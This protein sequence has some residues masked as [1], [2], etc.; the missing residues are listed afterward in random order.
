MRLILHVG[1][2]KTATSA[3]QVFARDN[4][5]FLETQGLF[6]PLDPAGR[7]PNHN[8]LAR[9]VRHAFPRRHR[10]VR[11]LLDT[12]SS[13]PEDSTVLISGE[14]FSAS[15]DRLRLWHGLDR[16]DFRQLQS[17][18]LK[19]LAR[20][21]H[22]HD[23]EI[24]LVFRRADEY[25]QSLYQTLIAEDRYRG[26]FDSFLQF[27]APLFDYAAQ[28]QAFEAAFAT[29]TTLSFHLPRTGMVENMFEK[30]GF[31]SHLLSAQRRNVSIDA[32]LTYW[33]AA[34]NLAGKTPPAVV[35]QQRNFC[36]SDAAR[37]LFPHFGLATFWRSAD[38]RKRFH[39]SAAKDISP[40]LFPE[41]QATARHHAALSD[42]ERDRV[43]K[44]FRRWQLSAPDEQE[45][46]V[47]AS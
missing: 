32:R 10:R 3:M 35:S 41:C 29:V 40:K 28:R 5:E 4:R 7:W 2:H 44:A 1:T 13:Y 12:I 15:C 37:T 19:R 8:W 22:D 17:R 47:R 6:Y 21:L 36:K 26:S 45:Q 27:S 39:N 25:A 11:N 18:Y 43:A 34:S 24:I 9:H 46:S 16:P 42:A 38:D 23:V 14:D 31:P 30:M 20:L 33:M